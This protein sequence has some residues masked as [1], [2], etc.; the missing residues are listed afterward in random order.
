MDNYNLERFIKAQAKD[1]AL[2]LKEIKN[3]QKRSHWIWYIFPQLKDLGY[4]YNAKYYGIEDLAEAKAYLANDVLNKHLK[5][6]SLELLKLDK[7]IITIVGEIDARKIQ[8][9]MTLFAK[10]SE[11]KQIFLDVLAKFYNSKYDES[12]L[13]ILNKNL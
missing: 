3:G 4:S 10:A 11:D 13:N 1:Y 7:D 5:E 12:T 8:S 2:A 9:S 6:I